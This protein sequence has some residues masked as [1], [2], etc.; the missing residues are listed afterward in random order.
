MTTRTDHYS[1]YGPSQL[2]LFGAAATVLL[3]FAWTV[4]LYGP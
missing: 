3:G 2:L 1:D 4:V